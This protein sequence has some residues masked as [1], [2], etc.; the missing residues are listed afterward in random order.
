MYLDLLHACNH[1]IQ[2]GS[3]TNV[4]NIGTAILLSEIQLP[5]FS[6]YLR[7]RTING[8][9]KTVISGRKVFPTSVSW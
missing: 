8:F 4:I 9:G 5:G 7:S 6:F 1:I 3:V 2:K